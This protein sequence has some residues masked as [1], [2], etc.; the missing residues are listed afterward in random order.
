MHLFHACLFACSIRHDAE[1]DCMNSSSDGSTGGGSS[2]S[3]ASSEEE[4][5]ECGD[6]D[7]RY[8]KNPGIMMARQ[9]APKFTVD[10]ENSSG[11]RGLNEVRRLNRHLLFL[12]RCIEFRH[13]MPHVFSCRLETEYNHIYRKRASTACDGFF[14]RTPS[15]KIT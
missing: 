10:G 11:A 4:E 15:S 8:R 5:E 3:D 7:A 9:E 14:E 12:H 2:D 6:G 13:G 1:Q